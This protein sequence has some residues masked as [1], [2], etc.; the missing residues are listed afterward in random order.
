MS[1]WMPLHLL[2]QPSVQFA[3]GVL[4]VGHW[5][6][7][8]LPTRCEFTKFHFTKYMFEKLNIRLKSAQLVNLHIILWL[9]K[10]EQKVNFNYIAY[11]Y[12]CT[13]CNS[14]IHVRTPLRLQLSKMHQGLIS[15]KVQLKH[16]K[17]AYLYSMCTHAKLQLLSYS[18]LYILQFQLLC[19]LRSSSLK[20]T[21]SKLQ[22][23]DKIKL[24]SEVNRIW[25]M[26]CRR[27][28]RVL[29]VRTQDFLKNM[30]FFFFPYIS[31]L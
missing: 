27:A 29:L 11:Q 18:A 12:I 13:S 9:S 1:G 3:A 23:T 4:R 5:Q 22:P 10:T 30:W 20:V 16:Y 26:L 17:M 14:L 7:R 15:C 28:R 19:I 24:T 21:S 6:L 31:F 2:L 25:E 8:L